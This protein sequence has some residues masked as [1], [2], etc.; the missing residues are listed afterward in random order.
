M[1]RV[2]IRRTSKFNAQVKKT[3][4]RELCK[5]GWWWIFCWCWSYY[6]GN[7]CSISVNQITKSGLHDVR[8]K[9]FPGL[10]LRNVIIGW[11]DDI[12]YWLIMTNYEI[13]KIIRCQ[14]K[15]SNA[16]K[17]HCTAVKV[18]RILMHINTIGRIRKEM[19]S[20]LTVLEWN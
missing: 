10:K 8:I 6:I 11:H 14:L 17:Y 13:K 16:H 12:L 3:L 18:K 5:D 15:N 1:L 4:F 9:L 20:F 7:K 2:W 19:K